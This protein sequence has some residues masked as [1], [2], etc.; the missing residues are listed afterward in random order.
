MLKTW[1]RIQSIAEDCLSNAVTFALKIVMEV[2][3]LRLWSGVI[4]YWS[5]NSLDSKL[6]KAVMIFTPNIVASFKKRRWI[7][8]SQFCPIRMFKQVIMYRVSTLDERALPIDSSSVRSINYVENSNL[9]SCK[10]AFEVTRFRPLRQQSQRL[11][12]GKALCKQDNNSSNKQK[13]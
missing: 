9:P 7:S 13:F 1:T 10:S 6:L 2:S 3:E 5:M 12:C 8:N 4:I 11:K